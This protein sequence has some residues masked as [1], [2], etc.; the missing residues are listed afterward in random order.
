M[1]HYYLCILR[2]KNNNVNFQLLIRLVKVIRNDE[3]T[4]EV[5]IPC[6]HR[7]RLVI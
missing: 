1:L 6:G 2:Y 7:G 5:I 4:L 3:A